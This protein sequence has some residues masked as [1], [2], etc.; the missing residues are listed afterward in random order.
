VRLGIF[1]G[2]FDPPHNGHLLSAVDAAE[3]LALDTLWFVPNATQPLK[4]PGHG[5]PEHR[6]EMVRLMVGSDP[7]FAVDPIEIQRQGPSYT[8]DTVAA[9]AERFPEATR[10][11]LI[12]AD[13]VATFEQWRSP[14]RIGELAELVVLHRRLQPAGEPM[15]EPA[16]PRA[17]TPAVLRGARW[18]ETRRID[19]SS[20][21]VRRRV[22]EGKSIRGFVPD[23]VAAYIA[24]TGLYQ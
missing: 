21:E 14:E 16:P 13:V 10:F 3:T 2:T 18:L 12:G 5:A 17:D 15:H 8:V 24:A 23:P 1:G 7:R 9:F 19:L 6:L 11:L 4:G 20:T 22:R